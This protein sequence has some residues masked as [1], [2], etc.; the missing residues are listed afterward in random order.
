MRRV[1]KQRHLKHFGI[2]VM[3]ALL[4]FA[5]GMPEM[6]KCESSLSAG[7]YLMSSDCRPLTWGYELPVPF[8]YGNSLSQDAIIAF[9]EAIDTWEKRTGIR[10]FSV[11][12][13]NYPEYD[14]IE[15]N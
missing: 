4:Q 15:F 5:C 3:L 11:I 14:G 1:G 2:L 6:G 7:R 9:N 13:E 12:H 8:V 10:L